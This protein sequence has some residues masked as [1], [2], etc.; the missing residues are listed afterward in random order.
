MQP[1]PTGSARLRAVC[2]GGGEDKGY[3]KAPTLEG[4]TTAIGLHAASFRQRRPSGETE[5]LPLLYVV[6]TLALMS[7][8]G[9]VH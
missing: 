1:L 8:V 7:G 6:V 4:S 5:P 3:R 9:R 2:E